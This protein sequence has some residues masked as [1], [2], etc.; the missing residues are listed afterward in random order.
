MLGLFYQQLVFNGKIEDSIRQNILLE[1]SE[2]LA[3]DLSRLGNVELTYGMGADELVQLFLL[4]QMQVMLESEYWVCGP[5]II[6]TLALY[7]NNISPDQCRLLI[8]LIQDLIRPT[9]LEPT[10]EDLSPV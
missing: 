2:Q 4:P 9:E 7:P 1:N 6:E 8:K 3:S 5:Q 10:D